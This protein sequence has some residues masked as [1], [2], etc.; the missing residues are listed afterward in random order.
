MP[1][2][3][4][5]KEKFPSTTVVLPPTSGGC[6]AATA[7]SRTSRDSETKQAT[8]TMSSGQPLAAHWSTYRNVVHVT[9]T[10]S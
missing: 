6:G 2:A 10:W 7:A 4:P 1:Q 9:T 8:K 3:V 5:A